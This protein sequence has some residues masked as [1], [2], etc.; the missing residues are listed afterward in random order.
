MEHQPQPC[1]FPGA[2]RGGRTKR[3]LLGRRDS[4][5][6][7]WIRGR[8]GD[9]WWLRPG[10]PEQAVSTVPK[11]G[12]ALLTLCGNRAAAGAAQP[13]PSR[14]PIPGCTR[15]LHSNTLL[16]ASVSFLAKGR[17][18][19][20]SPARLGCD[21]PATQAAVPISPPGAALG[22]SWGGAAGTCVARCSRTPCLPRDN[23]TCTQPPRGQSVL[24]R[25]GGK[26]LSFPSSEDDCSWGPHF[27]FN[28]HFLFFLIYYVQK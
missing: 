3:T 1:R 28:V 20:Q 19:S 11:A 23:S 6:H 4:A 10:Q 8:W 22:G 7:S 15:L 25:G 26:A 24:R 13:A 9:A 27:F 18:D 12:P 5:A 14:S 21:P 16:R 2:G 17:R